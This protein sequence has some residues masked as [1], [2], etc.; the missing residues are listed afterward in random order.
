V[1]MGND[2]NCSNWI[3]TNRPEDPGED[4]N[5]RSRRRRREGRS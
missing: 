4:S 5:R 1:M 2:E 3:M